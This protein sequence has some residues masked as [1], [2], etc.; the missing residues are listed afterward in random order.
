M[1]LDQSVQGSEGSLFFDQ[2]DTSPDFGLW[3]DEAWLWAD[4]RLPNRKGKK[5]PD[6]FSCMF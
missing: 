4:P 6:F 1:L 5:T 2:S 3:V